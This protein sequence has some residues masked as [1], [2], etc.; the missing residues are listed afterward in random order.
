MPNLTLLVQNH[1]SLYINGKTS[2]DQ[3]VVGVRTEH[4][5]L[6]VRPGEPRMPDTSAT[7]KEIPLQLSSAA[8]NRCLD[9][10]QQAF[11]SEYTPPD[12]D[13]FRFARYLTGAIKTLDAVDCGAY[14][15]GQLV[16]PNNLSQGAAY[17]IETSNNVPVHAVLGGVEP[18]Y[19]LSVFG[20]SS[21][22]SGLL[23]YTTN[24]AALNTYDATQMSTIMQDGSHLTA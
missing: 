15:Q 7:T 23:I 12:Y 17:W 19:G 9:F 10:Y 11:V 1:E 20:S 8:I 6:K 22:G 21:T 16:D 24:A 2:S 13:C 5:T 18:N 14:E 4:Q 3:L